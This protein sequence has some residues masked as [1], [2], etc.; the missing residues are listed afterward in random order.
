MFNPVKN[1]KWYM[2]VLGTL[3]YKD[4]DKTAYDVIGKGERV[5][6]EELDQAQKSSE[7]ISPFGKDDKD[8]KG[9]MDYLN[10]FKT[11]SN[12]NEDVLYKQN[13]D[14]PQSEIDKASKHSWF[15]TKDKDF[16]QRLSGKV[17]SWYDEIF[18]SEAAQ[19]DATGK[20]MNPTAKFKPAEE[21]TSLKTKEG[22][23]MEDGY[24]KVSDY[25]VGRDHRNAEPAGS[26]ALQKGLNSFSY[27][28]ALK[29]DG[30]IGP[31]T[32]SR[33]K[34]TLVEQGINSLFKKIG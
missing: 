31:K 21:E 1:N 10:R 17:S 25:L 11:N 29:E 22:L 23:D 16:S 20:L 26:F 24:K 5:T 3:N 14:I 12:P 6:Q 7:E 13:K 30:D 19:K 18:G 4:S 28:P 2:S 32:T 27:Q 9:I 15:D 33:L 34:Q 8:S